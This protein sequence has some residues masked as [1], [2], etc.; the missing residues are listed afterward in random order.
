M[1]HKMHL[2]SEHGVLSTRVVDAMRC[3]G[4]TVLPKRYAVLFF[5]GL[6]F[7][8]GPGL[9]WPSSDPGCASSVAAVIGLA[10]AVCIETNTR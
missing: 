9:L 7:F 8:R 4:A 3:D 2:V 6:L 5:R 10:G 1:G